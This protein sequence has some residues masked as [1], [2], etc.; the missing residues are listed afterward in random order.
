MRIRNFPIFMSMLNAATRRSSVATPI[1]K[2]PVIIVSLAI[3]T[4]NGV[5]PPGDAIEL[6]YI[7]GNSFNE[8]NV[9]TTTPRPYTVL[10][11]MMTGGD[12]AQ[13]WPK[14]LNGFPVPAGGASG[15]VPWQSAQPV[16][17][18][19]PVDEIDVAIVVA[20]SSMR[21]VNGNFIAGYLRILED[22]PRS[23]IECPHMWALQ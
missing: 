2:G 18:L 19:I 7:I 13:P 20:F 12:P 21:A 1:L 17:L 8:S 9:L 3:G 11:E 10:T 16:P 6:G 15:A 4:T 14:E 23:V 5:N 22:V